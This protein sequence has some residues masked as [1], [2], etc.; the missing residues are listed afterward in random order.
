MKANT[1]HNNVR[2]MKNTTQCRNEK[3]NTIFLFSFLHCFVVFFITLALFC[4][5]FAFIPTLCCV[6]LYSY[7][8]LWCFSYNVG[9]KTKTPQSNVRI[10][11][12]TTKQC[13]NENKNTTKQCKNNKKNNTM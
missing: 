3:H 5:V 4:G 1:P 2:I 7:I 11:K 10:M 8:V 6:F 12:N 13:R 9:M